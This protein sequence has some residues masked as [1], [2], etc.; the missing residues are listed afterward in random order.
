MPDK[1]IWKDIPGYNGK[2]QASNL[3]NIRST[4]YQNNRYNIKVPRI[5]IMKPYRQKTGYLSIVLGTGSG[6]GKS[7]RLHRLIATTFIPNPEPSI[8]T[9]VDHINGKRDDNRVINLRWVSPYEN[10]H[11][12]I[13]M[14]SHQ[15]INGSNSSKKV[16]CIDTGIVYPSATEAARQ[17]NLNARCVMNVCR[18]GSTRKSTG[19]Y[20]FRYINKE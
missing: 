11:N 17:M 4:Y 12:P 1:E 13:C 6:R 19:G 14:E 8:K 20:H 2:Y 15:K 5:L 9:Q 18:E 7:I 16:L 3:G 10:S